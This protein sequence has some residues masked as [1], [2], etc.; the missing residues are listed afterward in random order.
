MTGSIDATAAN[1]T[2]TYADSIAGVTNGT[3]NIVLVGGGDFNSGSSPAL[4]GFTTVSFTANATGSVID[5]RQASSATT[6]NFIAAGLDTAADVLTVNNVAIGTVRNIGISGF[7][8]AAAGDADMAI[9]LASGDSGTTDSITLNM[10]GNSTAGGRDIIITGSAG[11]TS[12]IEQITINSTGALNRWDSLLSEDAAGAGVIDKLTVIGNQI[13]R[14]DTEAAA[15]TDGLTIRTNG[16]IDASAM[17]AGGINLLVD[18]GTTATVTG[19][20]FNDTVIVDQ[21]RA[22]H[23]IN[24]GAGTDVIGVSDDVAPTLADMANIS[25]YEVFAV[26]NNGA[27]TIDADNLAA[28]T[29]FR[30][31]S[32]G[33]VTFDDL[34][35]GVSVDVAAGGTG[36]VTA[37]LKTNTAA[38]EVN[39]SVGS[40]LGALATGVI[41]VTANTGTVETVNL[42]IT[43]SGAVTFGANDNVITAT[44]I[45]MTG[46]QDVT[47]DTLNA[48]VTTLDARN[49]TGDI[50]VSQGAAVTAAL[51][52]RTGSGDDTITIDGGAGG[53]ATVRAGSGANT[54]IVA[55]AQEHVVVVG[56]SDTIRINDLATATANAAAAIST[57]T[58]YL[59]ITGFNSSA[60]QFELSDA[61]F[62][63][64]ATSGTLAAAQYVEGTL[65]STASLTSQVMTLS[66]NAGVADGTDS[67][68]AASIGDDVYVFHCADNVVAA[69][70]G[71]VSLIAIIQ[72]IGL[73]AIS[74]S[75]FTMIA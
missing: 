8:D 52:I 9:N 14:I 60:V 35:S 6:L 72:G 57:A 2:L 68:I 70:A 62:G 58:E 74:R 66:V 67:I 61:D 42:T 43:G 53:D 15:G 56:G 4:T 7:S 36:N 21:I 73:D 51:S 33:N 40:S 19:S 34:A 69:G 63:I 10:S 24:L 65:A 28:G 71:T 27:P 30:S 37:D 5:A 16:S 47:L 29:I 25:G 55:D 20:G 3:A 13:F 46:S 1:S 23:T 38:D 54:I 75:D 39:L 31:M 12:G 26:G 50:S 44:T 22:T 32:S 45:N 64:G 11:G 49:Y 41:T 17:T 59:T 48:A 18:L